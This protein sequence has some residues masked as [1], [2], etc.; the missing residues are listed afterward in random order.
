MSDCSSFPAGEVVEREIGIWV[1]AKYVF[2]LTIPGEGDFLVILSIL[3]RE[4]HYST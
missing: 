2:K 3:K 1:C 4:M